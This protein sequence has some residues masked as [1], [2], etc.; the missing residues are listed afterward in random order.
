VL[1]EWILRGFPLLRCCVLFHACV[2]VRQAGTLQFRAQPF[3][4]LCVLVLVAL[5]LTE[6]GGLCRGWP[7]SCFVQAPRLRVHLFWGVGGVATLIQAVERGSAVGGVCFGCDISCSCG[8]EAACKSLTSAS[9]RWPV[10]AQ[11]AQR[12]HMAAALVCSSVLLQVH[13]HDM[14][15][16]GRLLQPCMTFAAV[17]A[18]HPVLVLCVVAWLLLAPCT[19]H[20]GIAC[21]AGPMHRAWRHSLQRTCKGWVVHLTLLPMWCA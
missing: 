21:N 6:S 5:P 7:I 1:N 15:H 14:V 11:P 2:A 9:A 10:P 16:Q 20:G 18:V 4:L 3:L 13:W 8:S 17:R 12:T 19:G